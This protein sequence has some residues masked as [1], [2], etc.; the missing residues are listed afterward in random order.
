MHERVCVVVNGRDPE[1]VTCHF[2]NTHMFRNN[3]GAEQGIRSRRRDDADIENR[4][5]LQRNRP[6]RKH[7]G[8]STILLGGTPRRF[9]T[10]DGDDRD[11]CGQS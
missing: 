2:P 1:A 9:G 7:C 8:L 6:R 3:L 5:S 11:E 10:D 4:R